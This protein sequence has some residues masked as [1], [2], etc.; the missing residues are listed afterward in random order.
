MK[1]LKKEKMKKQS[2]AL[3]I[4]A[5]SFAFS[6]I[7][8]NT[9]FAAG[10]AA[11]NL[12]TAGNFRILAETLISDANPVISSV[13]GNV[14]VSAAAGSSITGLSCTEITGNIYDVDGTYTGGHNSNVTCL[15]AGPGANKTIVDNA[16]LDMG[17]AYTAASAPATPAGVGPALNMG[18]G[19]LSG[20]TFAPGAYTWGTPVTITGDIYLTGSA[21]DVWVFQIAGTL[22]IASGK[23]IVLSGGAVPANIFWQVTSAVTIQPGATF[24]GN[25]LSQTNI[26]M[27]AGAVLNGRALA[28]TAVTL[29][30]NTL[31]ASGPALPPATL[32]IIKS[33]SGGTA[34]SSDFTLHV[35]NVGVDVVGSPALGTSS[36][37]TA[38]SISAGVYA[39][40][41]DSNSSYTPSFS[42]DCDSS[43]N[44]T[45]ASA[46]NK[47]CTLTNTF[48]PPVVVVPH[49]SGSSGGTHRHTGTD[50][51]LNNTVATATPAAIALTPGDIDPNP[52][53]PNTGLAPQ[54]TSIRWD[55]ITPIIAFT[56]ALISF[57]VIKHGGLLQSKP[58]TKNNRNSR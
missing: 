45:L 40:S 41:E 11:V 49:S 33:V 18:G 7:G 17:T 37:G 31:R 30:G 55:V 3:T 2:Q 56:L 47:V 10:P 42:G 12:G 36:P 51:P 16:V 27:Q 19:T 13:T 32:H 4:L 9:I 34:T 38:Y 44:I 22:D 6:L 1:Q 21:S 48:I 5:L 29:I 50:V 24:E 28:Q 26:A 8:P 58:L 20:Q 35:K 57:V 43:G 15:L 52:G 46:D 23:K 14:G 53:F 54:E 39:V 25:I